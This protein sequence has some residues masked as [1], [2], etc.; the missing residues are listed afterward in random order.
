MISIKGIK[1]NNTQE[2]ASKN[3][4]NKHNPLDFKLK[5]YSKDKISTSVDGSIKWVLNKF[6]KNSIKNLCYS[7]NES[8]NNAKINMERNSTSLC[9][10]TLNNKCKTL[11][12]FAKNLTQSQEKLKPIFCDESIIEALG[13]RR[14]QYL[15]KKGILDF[16][17][18]LY[19]KYR[20]Y[21]QWK[22]SVN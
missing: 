21:G 8:K 6:H 17:Y 3:I 2:M 4:D 20:K 9:K 16:K 15:N 18:R 5:S 1:I 22:Y 10:Q 13:K 12:K 19:D 11:F 7:N 14:P